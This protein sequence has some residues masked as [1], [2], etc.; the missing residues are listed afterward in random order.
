MGV[1]RVV[2]TPQRAYIAVSLYLVYTW[3]E[4]ESYW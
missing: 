3:E 1:F 2:F 4:T